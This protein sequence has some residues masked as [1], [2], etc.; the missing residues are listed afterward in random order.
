MGR[1]RGHSQV[2]RIT[3][4][5]KAPLKVRKPR[6]KAKASQWTR[7]RV[8]SGMSTRSSGIS[9]Q[10]AMPE[11]KAEVVVKMGPGDGHIDGDE[12]DDPSAHSCGDCPHCKCLPLPACDSEDEG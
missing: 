8:K 9:K 12:G 11:V 10:T 1:R 5:G 2:A 4:G 6:R 3:T 7:P